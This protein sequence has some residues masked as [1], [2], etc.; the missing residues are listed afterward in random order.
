MQV[1]PNTGVAMYESDAIIKYLADTYG[2]Y[3]TIYFTRP[4]FPCS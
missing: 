3:L 1:D 2:L 4:C